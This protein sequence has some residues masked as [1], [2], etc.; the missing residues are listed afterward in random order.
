MAKQKT[1][2]PV[3]RGELE[4]FPFDWSE[5]L[6]FPDWMPAL[7]RNAFA[8]RAEEFVEGDRMIIRVEAPG[9][10][11]EKD[12][13]IRMLDGALRVMVERK[14]SEEHRGKPGYRSEIR[15]GMLSRTVPLPHGATAKS[16]SAT[17]KDGMLEV[18][19]PLGKEEPKGTHIPVIRK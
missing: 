15:Y 17:Y 6:R 8:L 13:D 5:F 7:G 18:M 19:V 10:D 4:L 3:E 9:I 11:P 14:E 2:A 1:V 16:V 12:V